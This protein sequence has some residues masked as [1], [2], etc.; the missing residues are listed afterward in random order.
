M[1]ERRA[2][3]V[4]ALLVLVALGVGVRWLVAPVLVAVLT[5]AVASYFCYRRIAGLP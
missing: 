4:S 1:N 3:M 5:P 2:L